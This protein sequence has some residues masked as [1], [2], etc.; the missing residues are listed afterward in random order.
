MEQESLDWSGPGADDQAEV[1][2]SGRWEQE[3]FGQLPV[4]YFYGIKLDRSHVLTQT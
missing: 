3:A 2:S 1:K 4:Y